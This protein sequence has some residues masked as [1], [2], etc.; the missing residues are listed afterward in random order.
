MGLIAV[1]A[2]VFA[3]S[4]ITLSILLLLRQRRKWSV[5]EWL[6][7]LFLS[8][9]VAYLLAPA[10]EDHWL[11]SAQ[12]VWENTLPGM[13]WLFCGSI[14]NDRFRLTRWN[15]SIV[16]LTIVLP[17]FARIM[18]KFGLELPYWLFIAIPQMIEFILIAAALF[19]V[20]QSW[21]DDLIEMRRDLRIWFCSIAGVYIFA[22]IAVREVL[23]PGASWWAEW[24]YIPVSVICLV[25]NVL[26]LQYRSGLMHYEAAQKKTTQRFEVE[27]NSVL[28]ETAGAPK[29]AIV[30]ET[31]EV[32]DDVIARLNQL[33]LE[34]H[35]YREMGLTIG[36]VA[37]RLELPEYKLR[38]M[39]NAGLGYRNFND[40]LNGFRIKEAGE[41]L[42]SPEQANEAVLNIALDTGFRSLSSFNK[43]FRE[44][45]GRTPTEY[46]KQKL[47]DSEDL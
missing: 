35:I 39:I 3:L 25:I 20:L 16:A 13:F 14:F 31:V 8:G 19:V 29:T 44:A 37:E 7:C 5:Q 38:K 28:S 15:V 42:A 22:T 46:R 21:K 41:R 43:A 34:E 24:Q 32:P 10:L 9:V 23:F 12:V 2:L 40:Y 1:I 6:F 36:Q 33:M 26:L 11:Q 17:A 45:Y 47:T 30:S 4:Q 18:S 27:T